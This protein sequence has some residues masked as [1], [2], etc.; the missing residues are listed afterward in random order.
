[1]K[2]T[3][4]ITAVV[5]T[6]ATVALAFSRLTILLSHHRNGQVQCVVIPENVSVSSDGVVCATSRS[7]R[8]CLLE[9]A[10]AGGRR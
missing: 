7:K 4:R 1:M 10:T 3:V 6:A 8:I 9:K 5:A 2:R